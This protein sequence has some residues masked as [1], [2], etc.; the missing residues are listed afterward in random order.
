MFM[1]FLVIVLTKNGAHTM[2]FT[3][4]RAFLRLFCMRLTIDGRRL[5]TSQ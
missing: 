1:M 5:V 4:V 2:L 3:Q